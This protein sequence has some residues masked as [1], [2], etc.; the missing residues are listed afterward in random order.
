M[1]TAAQ[2]QNILHFNAALASHPALASAIAHHSNDDAESVA[3]EVFANA[4]WSAITE[5]GDEFAGSL[6]QAFGAAQAL[7]FVVRGD[8]VGSWLKHL[9]NVG[10]ADSLANTF[11][12]LPVTIAESLDRWRPRIS[13]NRVV[14]LL[15]V[16]AAQKIQLVTSSSQYWPSNLNDLEAAAPSLLWVRGA[17]SAMNRLNRSWAL[18][19]SRVATN[20]GIEATSMLVQG[21]ADADFALVSGGAFGIDAAAHR[22][23]LALGAPTVAVMAGGLDRL[24]PRSNEQLFERILEKDVIVSEV[25][26]GTS[27]TKWRFLQRN[28]IIAALSQGTCVVEAGYRSGAINTANHAVGLG[29]AVG[30]VP[31]SVF[32]P[33]SAGTNRLIVEQKAQLVTSASDL[34]AMVESASGS[35]ILTF[36]F[37]ESRQAELMPLDTRVY[38]AIGLGAASPEQICERGGL[39]AHEARL[40]L[41]S[42]VRLG[43]VSPRG[44]KWARA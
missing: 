5:P 6:R 33:T 11:G 29:R 8:E 20:Y 25:T 37:Q 1:L 3:I 44:S 38:D 17:A 14:G 35:D 22:A 9:E 13:Q 15:D 34:I 16:A 19:G 41:T 36:D 42:L 32:A 30:A 7:A 28:R 2:I 39:T 12:S 10:L 31:G 40:G 21:L 23:S 43:L 26:P 4:A 18:V 27:P 24:Y